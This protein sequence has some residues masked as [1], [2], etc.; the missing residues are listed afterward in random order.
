LFR[1]EHF[2]QALYGNFALAQFGNLFRSG[3]GTI[4]E[5]SSIAAGNPGNFRHGRRKKSAGTPL[6]LPS[7][8]FII[9][10][11]DEY[12]YLILSYAKIQK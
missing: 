4:A 9:L 7:S 12:V 11:L 8:L 3:E 5:I 6:P 10:V 1:P 2:F